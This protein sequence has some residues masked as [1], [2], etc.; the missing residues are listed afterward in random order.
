MSKEKYKLHPISALIN[1]VKVLK[2]MLLPLIVII[3]ANGFGGDSGFLGNL[4]TF[5]MYGIILL[6]LLISGYVKWKRFRYWFEDEELRIE[7]GLFVKKKRYIPFE[8]IQSLNYTEG[9]FH[10]PFGL[11]KVKVETAGGGATKEA[12]AELTAI[13]KAAAEQIKK[14]MLAAKVRDPQLQEVELNEETLEIKE[15]PPLYTMSQKDLIILAS[16]SG[17]IGVFFSG[18]AVLV[19]QLSDVIPYEAI[20]NEIV[21]FIRF[22]V[23][24]V[25]L[26]IFAFILVAWLA[27]VILTFINYYQFTIR[28]EDED[29]IITR[30]LLEKKKMTIPLSRIQ[31]VRIIESPVRELFGYAAVVVDSAGGSLTDKDETMRLFP[32][33]KRAQLNELLHLIFPQLNLEPSFTLVPKRSRKF[34]YRLDYL[35]IIPVVGVTTYFFFPYGLLSLLLIPLSFVLGIWQHRTAGFYKNNLQLV[36]RYRVF[37]RV[38]I[39]MEKK[40]IQSMT[41]RTTYFQKKSGVSSIQTN[42][43]SGGGSTEATIPH[44]EL[45][46]AEALLEWFEPN[47]K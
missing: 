27:S 6:L 25:A 41:Q 45:E 21:V 8:R 4:F 18:L 3:L 36:A 13:T 35:W 26:A 28:L 20:Y 12:E 33:I 9:I 30:G 42:I 7:Y 47:R 38:T 40:R 24:M 11:V 29:I 46:D 14:E 15:K 31:A 22:G 1:F 34:F 32:L 43:K 44:I 17:G 2:E 16:T 23:L 37:S 5:G 19:S 10:R 39:W